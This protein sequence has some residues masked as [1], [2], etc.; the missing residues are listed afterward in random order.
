MNI[1]YILI[2]FIVLIILLSLCSEKFSLLENSKKA[3]LDK[4]IR[5]IKARLDD[6]IHEVARLDREIELDRAKLNKAMLDRARLDRPDTG[7]DRVEITAEAGPQSGA[8]LLNNGNNAY[9]NGIEAGPHPGAHLLNNGGK[10]GGKV[11]NNLN[12]TLR[13]F[14]R[15]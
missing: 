14:F 15:F 12:N 9:V 8:H 4:K 13:S 3:E 5:T 1:N 10:T 6:E 7:L 2:I 11:V